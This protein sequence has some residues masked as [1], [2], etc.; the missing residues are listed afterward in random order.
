MKLKGSV[1]TEPT[2]VQSSGYGK[3]N[4][5]RLHSKSVKADWGC[6]KKTDYELS[7]KDC[8]CEKGSEVS[9]IGLWMW[10]TRL[11]LF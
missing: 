7:E 10:K 6:E 1:I 8:G 2:E 4:R 5:S 3:E 11:L 9:K